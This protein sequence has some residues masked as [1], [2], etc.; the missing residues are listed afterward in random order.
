MREFPKSSCLIRD[1]V[2]SSL[3][4]AACSALDPDVPSA[5]D[6]KNSKYGSPATD[7]AEQSTN[8]EPT[9]TTPEIK[10]PS[11]QASQTPVSDPTNP[12]LGPLSI[13]FSLS[14]TNVSTSGESYFGRGTRLSDGSLVLTY[15]QDINNNHTVQTEISNDDGKTWQALGEIISTP[16]IDGVGDVVGTP[17]IAVLPSGTLLAVYRNI[18]LDGTFR[19]QASASVDGG[20]TWAASGDI[21]VSTDG[22]VRGTQPTLIVNSKG[23]VQVYYTKTKNAASSERIVVMKTS[24]DE[25][26]TWSS[27][28]IVAIRSVGNSGF[29]APVRLKDGSILVVFDSF[30]SDNDSH[31]VIRSVQSNNDGLS[32]SSPKDV[33]IPANGDKSAQSPQILLLPDGR[34]IVMFMTNEDN[35]A[36]ACCSIKVMVGKSVAS[37]NSLEWQPQAIVALTTKALIP[38]AIPTSDGNFLLVYEHARDAVNRTRKVQMLRTTVK[39]GL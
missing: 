22:N 24:T 1:L 2:V 3:L 31:L 11:D 34:P 33:Y 29:P 17:N 18:E 13:S 27:Q 35:G 39:G 4:F 19:L 36:D 20:R 23:Q 26:K 37:F 32:W 14:A 5:K 12:T 38:S 10:Q 30:R 8:Q 15:G 7:S 6:S 9:S 16:F 25:G 21:D 28:T